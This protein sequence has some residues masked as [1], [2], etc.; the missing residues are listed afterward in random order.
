EKLEGLVV[1]FACLALIAGR[2]LLVCPGAMRDGAFQQSTIFEVIGEDRFEEIQI[3]S[4]FG[5]F[6]NVLNYKQNAGSC[7][8]RFRRWNGDEMG[9]SLLVVASWSIR[10]GS[11]RLGSVRWSGCLVRS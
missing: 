7:L 5:I 8:K 6:Q 4:R 1:E 3:R 2:H 9:F 11:T 10:L